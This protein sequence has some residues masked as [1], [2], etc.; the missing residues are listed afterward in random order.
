MKW[1]TKLWWKYEL[2]IKQ[3]NEE[4][5]TLIDTDCNRERLDM[6]NEMLVWLYVY[7]EEMVDMIKNLESLDFSDASMVSV[8][9]QDT[10]NKIK[11]LDE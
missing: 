3:K 1:L 2:M 5:M 8:V 7:K 9:I 10:I 4:L 6:Y 11:Y